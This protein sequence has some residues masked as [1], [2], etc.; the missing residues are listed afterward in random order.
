MEAPVYTKEKPTQPG[1]YFMR[2]PHPFT[3]PWRD[4][5]V[6]LR[7][8]KND[9]DRLK[10]LVIS[11]GAVTNYYLHDL[12]SCWW[13]GP[14]TPPAAPYIPPTE[15]TE[16]LKSMPE[17]QSAIATAWLIKRVQQLEDA[18]NNATMNPPATDKLTVWDNRSIVA[19]NA[20]IQVALNTN[21]QTDEAAS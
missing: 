15:R 8:D 9:T 21:P 19:H 13:S 2:W 6:V 1:I 20:A 16:L 11:D 18:L 7:W 14:I 5:L 17:S 4:H 3:E 10:G 12:H